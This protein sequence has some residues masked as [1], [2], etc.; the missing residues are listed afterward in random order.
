MCVCVCVCVCVCIVYVY[1]YIYVC[2][3]VYVYVRRIY[4]CEENRTYI[5]DSEENRICEVFVKDAPKPRVRKFRFPT[6][7]NDFGNSDWILG[8]GLRVGR[9]GKPP[10]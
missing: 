7:H 9:P 4:I 10:F 6:Y 2:M 8:R 5:C 3:Y 1:T